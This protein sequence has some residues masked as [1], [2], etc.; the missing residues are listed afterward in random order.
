MT[1]T[2]QPSQ[3]KGAS[4]RSRVRDLL[5]NKDGVGA[6]EFAFVAPI[7]V[8]L[9]IGAVEM[10][11]AL[12]V[13]TKVS[14]AGNITL[15]LLTQGVTTSRS[16]LANMQNVARSIL[17][18]FSDDSVELAYTAIQVNA[19]GNEARVSWSWRSDG[20]TLPAQNS[21]IELPD[22]LMIGNAYYVRGEITNTHDLITSF[23]FT[24]A[25]LN[26]ID[27]SETYFMRPRVGTAI[28]CS[29][30]NT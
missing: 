21:V 23:P 13:D 30:C 7:L 18:P 22:S 9:Y 24:G 29:D 12:S 28:N 5:G 19:A 14:R 25:S 15:D 6:I 11:V 2:K 16:Q 8:V 1:P 3:N 10:T 27:L 20:G 17:S 4:L 26:S